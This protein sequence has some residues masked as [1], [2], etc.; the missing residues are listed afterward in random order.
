MKTLL[1][2]E[3]ICLIIPI[4]CYNNGDR[5]IVQLYYKV[6]LY[7]TDIYIYIYIYVCLYIYT[8]IYTYIYI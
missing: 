1:G 2:R 5:N 3:D 8:Y 7:I 4:L 6:L